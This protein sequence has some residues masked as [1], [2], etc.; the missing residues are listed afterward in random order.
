MGARPHKV[1]GSLLALFILWSPI[2]GWAE[3]ESE[4]RLVSITV[5]NDSN[6]AMLNLRVGEA[7]LLRLEPSATATVDAAPKSV[8]QGCFDLSQWSAAL[9]DLGPSWAD[10]HLRTAGF[11]LDA[12]DQGEAGRPDTAANI[13]ALKSVP[14]DVWGPWTTRSGDALRL[15]AYASRHMVP[16]VVLALAGRVLPTTLIGPSEGSYQ[17]LGEVTDLIR[18]AIELHGDAIAADLLR[19]PAW[20]EDRG[21][22][23]PALALAFE[24]HR[25]Q[26]LAALQG[27]QDAAAARGSIRAPDWL[28]RKRD[29]SPLRPIYALEVGHAET[30]VPIGLGW[31]SI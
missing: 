24:E 5:R 3:D 10:F 21:L 11:Y 25:E 26:V 20:A 31:P 9:N 14:D 18:V 23:D 12:I 6:A 29:S 22:G 30:S 1:P 19:H 7:T 17:K 16:D 28:S 15:V 4:T 8:L 13:V 27:R 2:V